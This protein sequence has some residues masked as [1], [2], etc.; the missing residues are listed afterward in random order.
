VVVSEVLIGDHTLQRIPEE[1]D[2]FALRR[3]AEIREIE[4]AISKSNRTDQA[5]DLFRLKLRLFTG[6]AE[7]WLQAKSGPHASK[8]ELRLGLA[9]ARYTLLVNSGSSSEQ[10]V[11]PWPGQVQD[12]V[13][14][15][16]LDQ[17]LVSANS[18][19]DFIDV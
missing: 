9:N 12:S 8:V 1:S 17:S 7:L 2:E 18:K 6:L 11:A 10:V 5:T 3:V 19:F 13:L 4:D 14:Y 16:T 15:K